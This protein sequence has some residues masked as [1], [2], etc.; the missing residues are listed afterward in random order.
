[1]R[2]LARRL[3]AASSAESERSAQN[4]LFM[5][6][7]QSLDRS[8]GG[9][10]I[11]LA[12]VQTIVTLHQGRVEA[13]STPGQGSEFIVVLPVLS[14]Q[15]AAAA[16]PLRVLV[17]D[18]NVDAAQSIALLLRTMGHDLCLAYDGK[19]ALIMVQELAPDVVL[20]DIGLPIL[21]G[22]Q[23]AKRVR[24]WPALKNAVLV[25]LTGY[26]QDSDRQRTRDAG[27]HHHLVKPVDIAKIESILAEV[28]ANNR[29]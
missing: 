3:A 12:I 1:M 17:V 27:F 2:D 20:L 4:H 9:L 15:D 8:Q 24:E 5:Q 23:V 21:D 19:S 26:G 13:R 11:G 22:F 7:E 18:D 29:V 25:A 28:A 10:G 16:R 14:S 6:A